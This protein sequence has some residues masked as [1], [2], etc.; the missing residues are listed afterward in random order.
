DALSGDLLG[1]DRGARHGDRAPHRLVGD[2]GDRGVPP[3]AVEVHPEGDLVAT[4][5]V[6][7]VHLGLV[8]LAQAGADLAL[9]VVEDELLVEVHQAA[10]RSTPKI[11]G[12][13]S[14]AATSASISAGVL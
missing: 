14:S 10:P 9:G 8:P 13:V 11:P 4:G 12:T 3:G 1:Q 7:V 2:V 5:R 6:D